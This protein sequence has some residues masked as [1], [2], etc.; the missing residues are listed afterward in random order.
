MVLI[1]PGGKSP[2]RVVRPSHLAKL[3][4]PEGHGMLILVPRVPGAAQSPRASGTNQSMSYRAWFQC[5]NPECG[6]TYPLNR[7]VYQCERCQSLLE[8][9]H[10]LEA[11]AR[12]D[13]K[14]WTKLFED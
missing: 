5:I 8:V 14:G 6:A 9:R 12:R 2:V 7:I 3:E 4:K 1:R 11:L 10:D 13:A